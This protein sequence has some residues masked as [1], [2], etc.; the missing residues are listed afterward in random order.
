MEDQE[1]EKV[2]LQKLLDGVQWS[3]TL[4]EDKAML[5]TEEGKMEPWRTILSIRVY[6]K[7]LV[8]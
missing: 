5:A 6:A 4:E 3:T 8:R 7:G 1:K 2:A